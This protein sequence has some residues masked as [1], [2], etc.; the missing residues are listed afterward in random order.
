MNIRRIEPFCEPE[1]VKHL[2]WVYQQTFGREPWNEGY[3]CPVCKDV[4]SLS[5]G[6]K[7]CPT[8]F[9]L[10]KTI[11]LTPYW[12]PGKVISDFYQEMLKPEA[13]CLVAQKGKNIVGLVWG[14]VVT[15]TQETELHLEAPGLSDLLKGD[16][17]YL[18]EAAVLPAYQRKGIGKKL[19]CQIFS[20]QR[21]KKILLRTLKGSQM[22]YLIKG[23][24]GKAILKI[25]RGR[26]IMSLNLKVE[27][28]GIDNH[29][30]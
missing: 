13:L 22:F 19:I 2:A 26:V 11:L 6:E 23:L 28:G 1:V 27:I 5:F 21:N 3:Q 7:I 20:T 4:F 18:D 30:T 10:G 25:S 12:P 24:G 9:N 17:F 15:I 16:F 8:C 29:T 14:Y